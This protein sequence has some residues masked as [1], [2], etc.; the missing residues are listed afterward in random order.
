MLLRGPAANVGIEFLI[1]PT[2]CASRLGREWAS[3][4]YYFATRVHAV[5]YVL[6]K[7]SNAKK[8]DTNSFMNSQSL[9]LSVHRRVVVSSSSLE[10]SCDL[11][12]GC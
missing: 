7:E 2:R 12:G 6:E 9:P 10:F 1:I 8:A 5:F 3:G 11:N 4:A